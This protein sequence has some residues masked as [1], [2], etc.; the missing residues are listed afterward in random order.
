MNK[1]TSAKNSLLKSFRYAFRGLLFL[2]SER[3]F[4]I[5][6]LATILV[7]LFGFIFQ[8][9]KEEWFIVLILIGVVM[10]FEAINTCL[11]AICDFISPN[12]DERI[13]KIKDM[14]AAAVL[15]VAI[16]AAI[17]GIILFLPYITC[18]I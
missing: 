12:F 15:I 4:R 9:E 13:K 10:G 7:V 2:F 14:A 18:C 5:H 6:I 16:V 3:N 17:I 1:Q 11:E 8:I